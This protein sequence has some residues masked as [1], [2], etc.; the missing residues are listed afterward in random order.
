MIHDD[1]Y[2]KKQA[3]VV[4]SDLF[5]GWEIH[6]LDQYGVGR[7]QMNDAQSFHRSPYR[8]EPLSATSTQAVI[9]SNLD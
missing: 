8:T 9:F 4:I 3:V 1:R 2:C 6:V 5:E 7:G